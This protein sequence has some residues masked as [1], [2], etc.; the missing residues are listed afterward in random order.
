MKK[1]TVP[2]WLRYCLTVSEAAE[3]FNIGEKKIRQIIQEHSTADFVL[4]NGVKILIKR[5]KFA[6]FIDESSSI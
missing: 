3:Y 1:E 2:I 5:E 6:Q 4:N